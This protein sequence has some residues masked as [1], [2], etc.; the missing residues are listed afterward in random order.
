MVFG[1]WDLEGF[2]V[3]RCMGIG[4]Y[5]VTGFICRMGIGSSGALVF[6][7]NNSPHTNSYHLKPCTYIRFPTPAEAP[8]RSMTSCR[9]FQIYGIRFGVWVSVICYTVVTQSYQDMITQTPD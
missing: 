1:D 3:M 2:R 8:V 7:V 5:S 4:T 9:R 6:G